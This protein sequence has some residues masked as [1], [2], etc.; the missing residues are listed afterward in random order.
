MDNFKSSILI[1]VFTFFI[2]F[3]VTLSSQTR[4]QYVNFLTALITLVIIILIGILSDMIGVAATVARKKSFNARAA[5]KLFG[6]KQ[7]L[8]LAKHGDRVASFMCD[9][10]GDICGTV[11]GA[12][13]AVIVIRIVSKWG[14]STTLINLFIIGIISALT[15]G[16]KAYLKS[17]GMKNADEIIFFVGKSIASFGL[18]KKMVQSKLRGE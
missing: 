16:G 14:G 10:I 9:I 6:A 5:K 3:L 8:Y 17:Y 2:A 1:A 12:I 18:L 7:G 11:S 15:V 4:V 13:G